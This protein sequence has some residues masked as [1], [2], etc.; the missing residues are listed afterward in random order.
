MEGYRFGKDSDRGSY[1]IIVVLLLL[2]LLAAAFIY[3]LISGGGEEPEPYVP[4]TPNITKPNITEPDVTGNV[5]P[6]CDDQCLYSRAMNDSNHSGC[7]LIA[8][9]T[10]SQEC[11]EQLSDVSLDACKALTDNKDCITSFADSMDDIS[12]CDLLVDGRDH[13]RNTVDPCLIAKD[14][15]ICYAL[16]EEDPSRCKSDTDCLLN[17]SM[18]ESDEG[19]CKLIQNPPVASGCLSALRGTD[20][21]YDLGKTSQKDLCYL[22][23][24]V[25]SDDWLTCTSITDDT[26]YAIDCYSIFAARLNNISICDQD[27][28]YLNSKWQCYTNYSLLSGNYS[29]CA[30]IHELA[31]THRF[32][33]AFSYAKRY[34]NPAACKTILSTS[35]R[36]TCYEGAILYS[37]QNLDWRY[38]ADVPD[39]DWR[40]KC[41]SQAAQL[42]G[43]VSLCEYI[44]VAYAREACVTNY[45]N[46]EK[47]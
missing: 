47:G 31:S 12:L 24:A 32:N 33:C 39:Y 23:Y 17:Y 36:A 4:V 3:A 22:T 42:Y 26:S 45:E 7:L 40:H 6:V 34:G 2:I 29:G 20:L 27:G 13:C 19:A 16:S 44:D 25:L 18:A 21:C 37:N 35:A 5:T 10:L 1:A 46:Y 14:K 15:N 38:C 9:S 28:F 43:D 30:E 8:N 41:F 11:L